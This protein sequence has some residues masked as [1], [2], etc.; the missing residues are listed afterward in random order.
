MP[1][2]DFAVFDCDSHFYEPMGAFTRHLRIAESTAYVED[3]RNFGFTDDEC[4][5]AMRG[6]GLGLAARRAA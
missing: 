1:H 5:R 3:L 6:N 4:R 2:I